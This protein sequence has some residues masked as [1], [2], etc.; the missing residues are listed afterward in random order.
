MTTP[1]V[2]RRVVVGVLHTN[3]WILRADGDHRALIVDPGD[4]PD[5]I[6][7][8]AE[9]LDV[10]ALLLTHTHFDHVLAVPEVAAALRVP[11]LAHPAEAPVWPYELATL[12]R[13]GHWNAGTATAALLARDPAMLAPRSDARLWDGAC[14]PIADGETLHIGPMTV[15][16]LHTPG[17]TPGGLSLSVAGHLLT[18]DTLFPG[19]PGLTG[20][21]LSDFA[22]IIRSV[23]RLLALPE[24]T[25]IHPGH[26]PDTAVATELPH[27]DEWIAR[28]W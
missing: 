15:Q 12:R 8:A 22:A 6:L 1:A 4:E 28:G 7:A 10:V 5:R 27:L 20:P 11:V 24:Q 3:C 21:P 18:G 16:A 17:H 14:T 9:G 19:G 2:L 13:D 26:G 23:R 25:R